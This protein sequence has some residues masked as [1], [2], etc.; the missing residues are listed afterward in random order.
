[1][2][3]WLP[4]IILRS[5]PL[6]HR[7]FPL[8]AQLQVVAPQHCVSREVDQRTLGKVHAILERSASGLPDLG[9]LGFAA[10]H[11]MPGLGFSWLGTSHFRKFR[12]RS[13]GART[14]GICN[15]PTQSKGTSGC[16]SFLRN[17]YSWHMISQICTLQ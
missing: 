14:P 2:T 6:C 11:P 3:L 5:S 12:D 15:R 4:L 9:H 10:G 7:V 8:L 1:M 16:T 17:C 13:N